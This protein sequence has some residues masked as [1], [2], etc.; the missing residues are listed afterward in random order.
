MGIVSNIERYALNDGLGVRTTIFLK[1]CPMRCRWCCN[2]E[3]QE[4]QRELMF[5]QDQCIGCGM[6]IEDCSY[7]AL[8]A[9]SV[10]QWTVCRNCGEREQAF[11]CTK[12]CYPQCRKICG[13]DYSVD[14]VM[15]IVKRDMNFYVKS[16]GGVTV[17][18]GEPFAQPGFLQDLLKKLKENWISTAVE[19]CGMWKPEDMEKTIPYIDMIF[20]DIK[21]MDEEKHKEWTSAGNSIIKENLKWAA[22][23]ARRYDTELIVRTPV[24]PG[25]NDTEDDIHAIC[26]FVNQNGSGITGMELLPYHKL[27]RGKYKSLGR[28]YELEK[29]QPPE[30][31]KMEKLNGILDLY[32]ISNLQF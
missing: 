3:T 26:S 23:L 30:E 27:G 14:D 32:A 12:R 8:M 16:G 9:D 24:I 20:F 6:C 25:F 13:T 10:P 15:N 31:E 19:T 21:S 5:F 11:S 18:G 22:E 29:L 7:D 2:P 4:F 17:S 1:G 28:D